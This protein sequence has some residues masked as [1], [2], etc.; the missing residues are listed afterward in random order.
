MSFTNSNHHTKRFLLGVIASFVACQTAVYIGAESAFYGIAIAVAAVYVAMRPVRALWTGFA[1]LALISQLYPVGITD[2][3][4]PDRGAYRPL[5][6]AVIVLGIAMS[7]GVLFQGGHHA[8]QFTKQYRRFRFAAVSFAIVFLALLIINYFSAQVTPT[9]LDIFR[10]SSGV[11]TMFGFVALGARLSPTPDEV[12]QSLKRLFLWVVTYS[13]F[14]SAKF[15]WI[16]RS[17]GVAP[18]YS[19]YRCSQ[20]DAV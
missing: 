4:T 10:A 14:F 1:L 16:S 2:L 19:R 5:I 9:I 11:I 3:G 15:L 18:F 6:A 8:T 17:L 7:V 12:R 20:R 13:F